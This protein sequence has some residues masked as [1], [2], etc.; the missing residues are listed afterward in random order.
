MSAPIAAIK[1][2]RAAP[3]FGR[4]PWVLDSAVDRLDPSARPG[5][6][7]EVQAENGNFIAWGLVNPASRIRIRLLSWKREEQPDR[8]WFADRIG[9]AIG[10]RET[11]GLGAADGACR[12]VNS[13][14]D[15]LSGLIVDRF[16][17]HL[18]IQP[19]GLGMWHR[20]DM[21]A[22]VLRE[23][24]APR[25]ILVDLDK[26]A[27]K[28]E[29]IE[30]PVLPEW[31]TPSEGAL[32]IV[33]HGITYRLDLRRGQKTGFYLDQ[34][35]NRRIV[36]SYLRGR[37]VADICCYAGGF[38]MCAA[39]LGGATEVVGVD[40]SQAAVD[41][42]KANADRNDCGNCRFETS[43]CFAW[44]DSAVSREE[45]FGG[46]ILDPPKFA[47]GRKQITTALR[48]YHR[49]NL[50]AVRLLEP[51]GILVTC[52]CTGSLMREEFVEMLHGVAVRSGRMIQILEHRGA[53]ADHPIGTH[54]RENE[55][56]KCLICRVI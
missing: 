35:D 6:L 36:A 23:R 26:Q 54:C 45:R 42:A 8:G 9:A 39:K 32:E 13:E 37:R 22:D 31:G 12:L 4:H 55:Y 30:A 43:D 46:V 41:I 1:Q 56:L 49:L 28:R 44:L 17:D 15:G 47:A 14:A 20:L 11:L 48:A 2:G 29:G 38:A 24:L 19:T 52:S 53:G 18:V 33:E 25:A 40:I 16:A 50:Q 27:A 5:D 21:I 51:G 10:L 3:F 7:V 34:R